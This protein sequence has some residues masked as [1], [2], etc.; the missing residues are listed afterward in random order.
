MNESQPTH[1][2]SLPSLQSARLCATVAT[3][4]LQRSR[5]FYEK[6]IGLNVVLEDERRGIYY[7]SGGGTMLNLYERDVVTPEGSVATFLVS[8]LRKVMSEL[9]SRAVVFEDYDLADLK[10]V[11]GVYSDE[12]GFMVCWF[13]DPDGNIIGIEQLP[14]FDVGAT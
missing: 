5:E 2:T 8:D 3:K 13:K 11:D 7:R 6:R 10:T 1:Y 14:G 12:T 4:D 9:R